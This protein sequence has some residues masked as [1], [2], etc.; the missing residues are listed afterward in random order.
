[1]GCGERIKSSEWSDCQPTRHV[2]TLYICIISVVN[3]SLST[4]LTEVPYTG[5]FCQHIT[6][7]RTR[8]MTAQTCKVMRQ[9]RHHW[10][11]ELQQ[12]NV[13]KLRLLTNSC[14]LKFIHLQNNFRKSASKHTPV[15][16]KFTSNMAAWPRGYN[17]Q[18][19]W[20]SF[21]FV[22]QTRT[23]GRRQ[24]DRTRLRAR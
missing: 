13:V 21:R 15:G 14:V 12:C 20:H 18:M 17:S 23:S 24:S 6:L 4:E 8:N 22:R 11:T 1:M 9:K 19:T 2:L 5:R 7:P 16:T 3:E 10:S